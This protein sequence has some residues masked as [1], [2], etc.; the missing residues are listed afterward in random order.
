MPF[1][2][3]F[4]ATLYMN[5]ITDMLMKI[6]DITSR[7]IYGG[8]H[9]I[10]SLFRMPPLTVAR[11]CIWKVGQL[12]FKP[13]IDIQLFFDAQY[14][15]PIIDNKDENPIEDHN[16]Q[17]KHRKVDLSSL[18]VVARL[19]IWK[20]QFKPKID[21]QLFFDAEYGEPIIDNKD[22]NPIEDHND[23]HKH[24]KV[25][26]S[27][28]PVDPAERP[29]IDFYHSGTGLNQEVGIKRPSDTRWGSH[30]SSPLNIKII[31]SSL[32]EVLEDLGEDNSDRDRKGEAIRILKAIKSFDFVFCLH[33]MVDILA[34]TN[35]LNTCLQRK[36]QDIVNAMIQVTLQD[37]RDVGWELALIFTCCNSECGTREYFKAFD[38]DRLMELATFY[39]EEFPTKYDLQVLE[40]ELK[41]YIKD[42]QEDERFHQLK[43]IG[44]LAKKIVKEQKHIIFP[45]VYL[46]MK[47]ALIFTCCNIEC[48]TRIFINE[49]GKDRSTQQNG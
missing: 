24:R 15:E 40:V 43:S 42:V 23:Q 14:G 18:P 49:V 5:N 21:I 44:E 37:I 34:V 1:G 33:F 6:V 16:D 3:N 47:L 36:D 28:L 38:L 7:L 17:H 2:L 8:A 20:L 19:C 25:D 46:L 9:K 29:S 22:E 4:P 12:Q 41:N 48:G 27:S 26:L 13:K 11:L 35:H 32:C 30:F 45:K 31:Y 39:E 10:I